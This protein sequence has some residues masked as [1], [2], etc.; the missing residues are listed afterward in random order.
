MLHSQNDC[1]FSSGTVTLWGFVHAVVFGWE[2]LFVLWVDF[3]CCCCWLVWGFVFKKKGEKKRKK[4]RTYF[5][6]HW[7]KNNILVVR[8][9]VKGR[10]LESNNAAHN[11]TC[12]HLWICYQVLYRNMI[13]KI[14]SSARY[15]CTSTITSKLN[16]TCLDGTWKLYNSL[17]YEPH[18]R[19][20][21]LIKSFLW[22]WSL[23]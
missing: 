8:N 2:W 18:F 16:Q 19:C 1:L 6:K 17:C 14:Y 5:L 11:A 15:C 9:N 21:S 10:R 7:C 13:F 23:L 20:C 3:F 22:S 12:C 4:G